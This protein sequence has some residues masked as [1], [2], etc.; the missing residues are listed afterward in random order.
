[1]TRCA[2]SHSCLSTTYRARAVRPRCSGEAVSRNAREERQG[3]VAQ[4]TRTGIDRPRF[5][6]LNRFTFSQKPQRALRAW[7]EPISRFEPRISRDCCPNQMDVNPY[8]P[9]SG[10][11]GLRIAYCL[12][13]KRSLQGLPRRWP[14]AAGCPVTAF[15][16][17][18]LNGLFNLAGI[19]RSNSRVRSPERSDGTFFF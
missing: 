9:R 4:R 12:S 5:S 7:R 16:A 3:P 10:I 6:G 17:D 14:T 19:L 15:R 2:S 18:P 1:M 8:T 11:P 13:I